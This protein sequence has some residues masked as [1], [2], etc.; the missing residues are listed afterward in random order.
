MNIAILGG[1]FDP[2]HKGHVAIA[3]RLLK[4]NN[5]DEVWLVPCYKHPFNKSLSSSDK[6]FQMTKCLEKDRI[7]ISDLEIKNKTTSYTIDTLRLLS[8]NYPDDKFSL[9]IGTDQ[10]ANLTKW[11]GWREIIDKFCLFV[12]H[13][14][15]FKK[16]EKG[17]K[18]I[19][20][21]VKNPQNII[22]ADRKK[23]PPINISS[24]LI[25]KR[26]KDCK[27]IS[28]LVPKK[29]EKYIIQHGLYR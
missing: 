19:V 28:N 25:R 8:K 5:F 12:I 20:K 11:K 29:V 7:R 4:L 3:S 17:L 23:Y 2:P 1:S 16:E 14:T 27:S 26:I 6:R 18:N 9:V 15:G 24:T 21:Q 22:L 13:R 10:I